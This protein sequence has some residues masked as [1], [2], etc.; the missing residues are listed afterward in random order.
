[1]VEGGSM[2]VAAVGG[3]VAAAAERVG[4]REREGSLTPPSEEDIV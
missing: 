3:E 1:M 4:V 2:V